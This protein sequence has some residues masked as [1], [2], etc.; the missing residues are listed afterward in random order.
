MKYLLD[1]NAL[2]AAVRNDHANTRSLTV[3]LGT[4]RW[5]SCAS[6]AGR[7]PAAGG[8]GVVCQVYALIRF[9]VSCAASLQTNQQ[10]RT[11]RD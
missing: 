8:P 2:I 11:C 7:G 10:S 3:G 4:Q 6:V 5:N 9:L 1:V